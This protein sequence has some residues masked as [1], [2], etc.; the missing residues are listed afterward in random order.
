MHT[1]SV[2]ST[3]CKRGRKLQPGPGA[4]EG[5]E[6]EE[7]ELEEGGRE[8]IGRGEE[9]PPKMISAHQRKRVRRDSEVVHVDDEEIE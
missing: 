1:L 2:Y 5:G 6:E 8:G 9:E 7:D 4:E 3:L